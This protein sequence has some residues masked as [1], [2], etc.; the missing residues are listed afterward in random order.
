[1]GTTSLAIPQKAR[2]HLTPLMGLSAEAAMLRAATQRGGRALHRL[3][4]AAERDGASG[5]HVHEA[6]NSSPSQYAGSVHTTT[7]ASTRASTPRGRSD[8]EGA[9][10]RPGAGGS[11]HHGAAA[12]SP[13]PRA[14][15]A[16]VHLVVVADCRWGDPRPAQRATA[17]AGAAYTAVQG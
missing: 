17:V 9:S 8:E 6:G 2:Q 3:V 7:P 1:M 11:T 13:S 5:L 16:P 14:A 15:A 12:G 4:P 10:P